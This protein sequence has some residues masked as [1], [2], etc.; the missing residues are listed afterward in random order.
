MEK[1]T[2]R[3]WRVRSQGGLPPTVWSRHG[4]AVKTQELTAAVAVSTN[5]HMINVVNMAAQTRWMVCSQSP[6]PAEELLAVEG[7]WSYT[8]EHVSST[9]WTQQKWGKNN[10]RDGHGTGIGDPTGMNVIK[11]HPMHV[12]DSQR[13]NKNILSQ[14][15]SY[16]AGKDKWDLTHTKII[17]NRWNKSQRQHW[18]G[19]TWPLCADCGVP[20]VF[21]FWTLPIHE[22][23]FTQINVNLFCEVVF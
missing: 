9:N 14:L 4:R 10:G 1:G 13:I 20:W 8:H 7:W 21:W 16:T 6:T 23:F 12:S 2:E 15:P 5:M 11:M 3:L 22:L 17:K 18:P 19:W